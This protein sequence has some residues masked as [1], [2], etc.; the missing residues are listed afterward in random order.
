MVAVL[1]MGYV[2]INESFYINT[3][4]HARKT[5]DRDYTFSIVIFKTKRVQA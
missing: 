1:N 4:N 2:K 3:N 5:N